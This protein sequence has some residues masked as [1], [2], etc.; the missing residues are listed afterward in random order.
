M[1]YIL[2]PQFSNQIDARQ[3]FLRSAFGLPFMQKGSGSPNEI[4]AQ[5]AYEFISFPASFESDICILCG[6]NS[7]IA[8]VIEKYGAMFPEKNIYL[9]TCEAG[10]RE[11]YRI[12]GKNI[13][14]AKQI[15]GYA[16]LRNGNDFGFGFD[17]TD[18]ELAIYNCPLSSPKEKLSVGFGKLASL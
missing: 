14:I 4:M 2:D 7:F 8:S 6:H 17:I 16:R 13:Y 11:K 9:I 5:L 12:K 18:A 15:K 10:Y 1:R 3:K